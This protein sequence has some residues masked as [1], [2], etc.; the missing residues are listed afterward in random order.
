MSQQPNTCL[1]WGTPATFATTTR[2]AYRVN[3]SRAG[4]CFEISRSACA[5][6]ENGSQNQRLRLTSWLIEQRL[7]GCECP[8][9]TTKILTLVESRKPLSVH[10]RADR[11]LRWLTT[12]SPYIGA[13]ARVIDG[14]NAQA[15]FAYSESLEGKEVRFLAKYLDSCGWLDS[16][17]VHTGGFDTTISA[18]G[19]ARLAELDTKHINSS[20]A[21][22]A[23][24]FD[25]GMTEAYDNGLAIGIRKA[26]YKPM[27]ID[28][29]DHNNKIDDEL[30]AEI[31]HS[32]FLVAD[33]TQGENSARGSVYYEAG[34]AHG[35]GIPVIFTY[36]KGS[37]ATN[38]FDT[39]QYNHIE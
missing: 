6:L 18:K 16:Y 25:Y 29:K 12:L 22:V 27:R 33:F 13:L 34:F 32:K 36:K 15:I 11:L 28:R 23:M 5:T 30:I 7:G 37:E 2:D 1:V 39:R 24:W 20:Q 3:S 14:G 19:Y 38:H 26:G 10:E 31:R 4:G 35:L 8:V 21:F 9:V 17:S